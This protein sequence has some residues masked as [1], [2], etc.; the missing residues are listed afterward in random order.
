M[1]IY[2][3]ISSYSFSMK[4]FFL[5]MLFATITF[6]FNIS[7]FLYPS[8]DKSSLV[9]Q[10]IV[11]D[12]K[13]YVLYYI[14]S[15][16]ILLIDQNSNIVSDSTLAKSILESFYSK[17]T[18]LSESDKTLFLEKIKAFNKSRDLPLAEV[19][20]TKSYYGTEKW[21]KQSVGL[22]TNPCNSSQS[23]FLTA[24]I[25]CSLFVVSGGS[26]DCDP[27]I[28]GPAI[29]DYSTSLNSLEQSLNSI[30]ATTSS[31]SIANLAESYSSILSAINKAKS[32]A[33]SI[34]KSNLMANRDNPN[35]IGVCFPPK[36]D[37]EALDQAK[38]IIEKYY[39]NLG[40][41]KELD[42]SVAILLK[43]SQERLNYFK[44]KQKISTFKPRWEEIKAKYSNLYEDANRYAPNLA[45][46]SF[47]ELYKKFISSWNTI[48]NKITTMDEKFLEEELDLISSI[49][50]K[51]Q[52]ELNSS[53]GP[54]NTYVQERENAQNALL[55]LKYSISSSKQDQVKYL[56][57]VQKK[58]SLD[59][60]FSPP[61]SS[62]KYLEAAQKY[63]QLKN[64]IK[65]ASV[66]QEP[67]ILDL[68]TEK[69]GQA[70]TSAFFALT[71]ALAIFDIST[72]KSIAPLIPIATLLVLDIAI[73]S[74]F[75]VIFFGIVIK[76]K[77]LFKNK[78]VA[79]FW[80]VSFFVFL[81]FVVVASITFYFS[82]DS[83]QKGAS[84]PDFLHLVI[85]NQKL[86]VVVVSNSLAADAQDAAKEC[87]SKIS[88][89]FKD[90]FNKEVIVVQSDQN[91]C[92]LNGKKVDYLECSAMTMG[93]PIFE[94]RGG[95][96]E[97]I[98]FDVLYEKKATYQN[99]K[100]GFES[101]QIAKALN[102]YS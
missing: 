75:S 27:Y 77:Q 42:A 84:L 32:A 91:S 35:S 99:N 36:F 86:Y 8:E 29:Y 64:E 89:I 78:T 21:C 4:K 22:E 73:I 65:E 38:A 33:L 19:S 2:L 11:Y 43:N 34:Q 14:N 18:L 3:N 68:S 45:D 92:V 94:L 69:F 54:Y 9:E 47:V 39:S 82:L 81:F 16:P 71:D 79:T 59:K 7:E 31:L 98:G 66:S 102:S 60:Q 63:I 23:C 28:L 70:S 55:Y 25:V 53:L 97:K 37:F 51:L 30:L 58:E 57:F 5:V 24:N 40:P 41:L 67:T 62:T 96:A 100:E 74:A 80:L 88:S 6:A 52:K 26:G 95:S 83:A 85:D 90:K 13:Q 101:C 93:Y 72:K 56:N 50:P 87:A 61:L 10:Q 1:Q 20:A 12:S 46:S 44:A 15:I 48:E 76:Y 49:A 17:D